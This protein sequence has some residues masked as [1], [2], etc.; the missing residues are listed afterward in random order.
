[1]VA[2]SILKCLWKREWIIVE[3]TDDTGPFITGDHPICLSWINLADVPPME[4]NNPGHGMVG[5]RI[6]FPLSRRLALIGQFMDNHEPT[7]LRTTATRDMV[8]GLNAQAFQNAIKQVYA[9]SPGFNIQIK[10]GVCD[11]THLI[12]MFKKRAEE[13]LKQERSP[14]I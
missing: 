6:I 2:Y 5:T 3:A 8:A 14:S 9:P 10:E 4:R 7:S 13:A 1:M 12:Q 11:G